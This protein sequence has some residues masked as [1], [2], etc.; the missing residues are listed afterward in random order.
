MCRAIPQAASSRTRLSLAIVQV[1]VVAGLLA[2]LFT[3]ESDSTD[4][5]VDWASLILGGFVIPF[6][7][8]VSYWVGRSSRGR[9]S[10]GEPRATRHVAR[11]AQ[12][13]TLVLLVLALVMAPIWIVGELV[14]DPMG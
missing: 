7:L 2:Y 4:T 3:A 14:F 11:I 5:T 12:G 10:S 13:L 9:A 1:A 6:I 8:G